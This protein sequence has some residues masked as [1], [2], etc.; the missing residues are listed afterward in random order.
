MIRHQGWPEIEVGT[1][2]GFGEVGLFA[3]GERLASVLA[4]TDLRCLVLP[5]R[6]LVDILLAEPRLTLNLAGQ[7]VARFRRLSE[8]RLA[9]RL[10]RQS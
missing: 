2:E 10:I 3:E 4:A 6:R 5:N 9:D 7:M 8:T 1:G